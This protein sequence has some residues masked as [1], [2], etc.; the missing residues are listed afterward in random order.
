MPTF[1]LSHADNRGKV[2]AVCYRR[3][4]HKADRRVTERTEQGIKR[5]VYAENAVSDER[6]P[7][8]ICTTC[9]FSLL[10]NMKGFKS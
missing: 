8:G 4:G 1:K 2:C 6:F 9:N 3:S 7:S 10:E 5:F